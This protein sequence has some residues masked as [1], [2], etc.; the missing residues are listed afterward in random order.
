M[1]RPRISVLVTDLLKALD[2]LSHKFL[3]AEFN[4]YGLETSA[5]YLIFDYLTNRKQFRNNRK[6]I[7]ELLMFS[8]YL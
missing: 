2:C 1:F 3:L 6:S 8:I 4:A 7:L 5:V